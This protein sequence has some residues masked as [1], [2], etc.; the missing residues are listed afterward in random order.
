MLDFLAALTTS[1]KLMSLRDQEQTER[2]QLLPAAAKV[3]VVHRIQSG[4]AFATVETVKPVFD[5]FSHYEM[6]NL[7]FLIIA[8]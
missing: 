7:L 8:D 5:C 3:C 1:R 4:N 2:H 6:H